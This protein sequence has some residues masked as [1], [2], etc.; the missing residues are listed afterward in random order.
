M[1]PYY[2]AVINMGMRGPKSK[3]RDVAYP[4]ATC[5]DFEVAGIEYIAGNG[6]YETK[7]KRV[8]KFVCRTVASRL[9][10]G[11]ERVF[12]ISGY[13][14]TPLSSDL[15]RFLTTFLSEKYLIYYI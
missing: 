11:V 1:I 14:R 13:I 6:T 12:T 8:R 3:F 9:P 5:P 15:R 7:N 10:A 2:H 4:N